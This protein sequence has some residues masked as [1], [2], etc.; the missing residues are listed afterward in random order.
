MDPEWGPFNPLNIYLSHLH[1]VLFLYLE[2]YRYANYVNRFDAGTFNIQRY[3]QVADL[4]NGIVKEI[5]VII[6]II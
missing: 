4:K 6:V 2:R 1:E 5:T 3:Q